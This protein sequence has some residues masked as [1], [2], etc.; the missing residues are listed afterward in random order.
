MAA[1]IFIFGPVFLANSNF[2]INLQ[3]TVINSMFAN[4]LVLLISYIAMHRLK[5][6]PQR[7]PFQYLMP[8]SI[9]SFGFIVSILLIYRIE[10]SV[11]IMFISAIILPFIVASF[12]FFSGNNKRRI[13]LLTPFCNNF[14]LNSNFRFIKLPKPKLPKI[15][16]DGVVVD[17]NSQFLTPEWQRF[18]S[19][20]TLKGVQVYSSNKLYET[21]SGRVNVTHLMENYFGSLSPSPLMIYF[22]SI[23]DRITVLLIFPLI[24]PICILTAILISFESEGGV[25]FR[26]ERVGLRGKKIIILKFRSMFVQNN[27]RQSARGIEMSR[28]TKV[29]KFIRKYRIDELPQFWNVLKGDLS[30]IGPRPETNVWTKKYSRNIPFYSYRNIVKP[31]ITGWAQVMQG[32][33]HGVDD[34]SLKLEYDFYYLRYFSFWLDFLIFFKTIKTVFIA[35]GSK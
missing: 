34:T 21:L 29:G 20:I 27:I 16:I 11:K 13:F 19:E 23:F 6:Y 1:F 25:F 33:V 2:T 7:N 4:S 14:N 30:L 9:S 12:Y 8:I 31:G 17:F 26:Q 3:S 5:N 28:L 32:H 24:I 18:L 35:Y 10:Y 22:K 15:R